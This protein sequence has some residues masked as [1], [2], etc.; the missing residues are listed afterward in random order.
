MIRDRLVVG[1]LDKKLSEHPQLDPDL[2]LEVAKKKIRQRET[3]QEQQQMLG[4]VASSSLEEVK[5]TYFKDK[6]AR[7]NRK[8]HVHRKNSNQNQSDLKSCSRC[9]KKHPKEKCPAKEAIC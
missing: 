2:T 3:V 1:I 4:G 9:G 7:E 5:Q 8:V 6:K